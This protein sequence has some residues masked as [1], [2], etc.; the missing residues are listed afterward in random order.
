MHGD[1][2]EGRPV[3]TADPG[4]RVSMGSGSATWVTV[5]FT[6]LNKTPSGLL[7]SCPTSPDSL[8]GAMCF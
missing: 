4:L 7:G 6:L 8:S 1:L 3:S 5:T 2:Q